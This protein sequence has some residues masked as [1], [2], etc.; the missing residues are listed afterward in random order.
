VECELKIIERYKL[1]LGD[2][3]SDGCSKKGGGGGEGVL[4][5]CLLGL[6]VVVGVGG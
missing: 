5:E 6:G 1:E 4:V 2:G 3:P